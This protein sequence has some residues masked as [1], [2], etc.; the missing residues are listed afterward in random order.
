[1]NKQQLLKNI[2]D[3]RFNLSLIESNYTKLDLTLYSAFNLISTYNRLYSITFETDETDINKINEYESI[4]NILNNKINK[5][6]IK[7]YEN[8]KSITKPICICGLPF[9]RNKFISVKENEIDDTTIYYKMIS[10][11]IN[12]I[13]FMRDL[14]DNSTIMGIIKDENEYK[15]ILSL[16][17]NYLFTNYDTMNYK[18]DME[19]YNN[20]ILLAK[21]NIIKLYNKANVN[22]D[23][24]INYLFNPNI[25]L[26]ISIYGILLGLE[27]NNIINMDKD[28]ADINDKFVNT[29]I[30]YNNKIDAI[31]KS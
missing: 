15:R 27:Y 14:Y 12:T 10:L 23:S 22:Y 28:I 19:R 16:F 29:M 24:I 17:N 11:G 13:N 31:Y 9:I 20:T 18:S 2:N 30:S 3:I 8:S 1:M 26:F 25:D 6:I 7:L 5:L 21:D 4:Y